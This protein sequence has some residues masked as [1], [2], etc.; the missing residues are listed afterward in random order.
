MNSTKIYC[1]ECKLFAGFVHGKQGPKLDGC[2]KGACECKFSAEMNRR[3]DPVG[4]PTSV[5]TG[6]SRLGED[7]GH[8]TF[9]TH[10][11]T[12]EDQQ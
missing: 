9:Y 5:G 8:G 7:S 4:R 11:M 10:G 1:P 6:V 12:A 3:F 2:L